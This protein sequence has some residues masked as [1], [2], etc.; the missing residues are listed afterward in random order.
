M[1]E[2]FMS[3]AGAQE[4]IT[5]AVLSWEGVTSHAHRFGGT[6]YRLGRREIGHIHGDYLVDIPFPKKVRNTVIAAGR[7]KPHHVLPDSGWVSFY[8]SQTAD[9]D[10]AIALLR[11]SFELAVNQ[12]KT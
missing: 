11:Q 4:Q 2:Y 1:E 5:Q 12:R 6:E 8:I 10:E 3:V 7:A 9:I